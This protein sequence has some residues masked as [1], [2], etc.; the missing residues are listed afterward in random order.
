M[1]TMIETNVTGEIMKRFVLSVALMFSLGLMSLQAAGP[2]VAQRI[3]HNDPADYRPN[4]GSHNGPGQLNYK[5]MFDGRGGTDV[6]S[7]MAPPNLIFMHRGLLQ[8]KSGI[9]HHF[10]NRCEEMFVIFDGEAQFTIDGR[11]SV[12]KAPAGAPTRAGHSHAIY[13]PSDRAIQWMNINVGMFQGRY[14]AFNLDD[15]RVDVPLDPVPVFM[16]MRLYRDLLR[17]VNNMDGGKGTLQYRRALPPGIFDG[18][19]AYVDHILLP[20]GTSVGNH[21]HAEVSEIYYVM[22]GRGS[23]SIGTLDRRGT[24]TADSAPI[25]NGDAVPVR[26]NEVHSI[27]NTGTEPLELMVVGVST[28]VGPFGVQNVDDLPVSA[29]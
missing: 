21:M 7:Q 24:L 12:L 19:W 6:P 11:T 27:E 13:N 18:P 26:V 3:A 29:K 2:S 5:A 25:V 14:D 28:S 9:G 20:P 16:T 22:N 15:G 8:A 1:S 23:V 4:A 17:P 10:H